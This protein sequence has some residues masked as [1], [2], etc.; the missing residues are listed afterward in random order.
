FSNSNSVFPTELNEVIDDNTFV[1]GKEV[2]GITS[3]SVKLGIDYSR[4]GDQG[5]WLGST[6][7]SEVNLWA[8]AN[9][10]FSIECSFAFTVRKSLDNPVK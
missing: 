3:I 5:R 4:Q 6:T 7:S 9:I 2:L 8:V 10:P 1:D